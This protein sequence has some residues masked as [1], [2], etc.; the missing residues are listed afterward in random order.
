MQ[1]QLSVSVVDNSP[2]LVDGIATQTRHRAWPYRETVRHR[3]DMVTLC[4]CVA[5]PARFDLTLTT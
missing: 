5:P 2:K 1:I 4:R 3:T